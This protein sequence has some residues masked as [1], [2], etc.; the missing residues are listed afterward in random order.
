MRGTVASLIF[1]QSLAARSEV[2]DVLLGRTSR[3]S[4]RRKRKKCTKK[5]RR[6][7]L[8]GVGHDAWWIPVPDNAWEELQRP[9]RYDEAS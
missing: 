6:G 3:A 1:D 7:D 5:P 8:Q 2:L 4:G 9:E